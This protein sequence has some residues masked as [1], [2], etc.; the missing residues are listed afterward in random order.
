MKLEEIFKSSLVNNE[1]EGL[2]RLLKEREESLSQVQSKAEV[3]K[4]I[5]EVIEGL[6]KTAERY[7]EDG[8]ERK[9][10]KNPLGYHQSY[11]PGKYDTAYYFVSE[12]T[13]KEIVAHKKLEP[14]LYGKCPDCKDKLPVL[15]WYTQT[16]DS[17]DGDTW[18]KEA[19]MICMPCEKI[20]SIKHLASSYRFLSFDKD[21]K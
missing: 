4:E 17:P 9:K 6:K 8:E 12:I 2:D 3:L 19:F 20:H 14:K 5:K 10:E 21:T 1:L 18:E 13:E 7:K 11:D 16:Y 15:M